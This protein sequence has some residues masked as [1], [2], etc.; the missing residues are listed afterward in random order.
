[1][2]QRSDILT[3]DQAA[4]YLQVNRETIYRY[5]RD[6]RLLAS[7]LGRGYRIPRQSLERLLWSTRARDDIL[8]REY[9]DEE[10]DAFLKAD[11]LTPE[12]EAIA[13]RAEARVLPAPERHGR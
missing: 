10:L 11:R 12:Q 2:E 1:M 6:G 13:E 8:L 7:R 4:A 9:G 3:P 5:I